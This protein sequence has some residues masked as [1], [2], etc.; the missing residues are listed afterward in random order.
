MKYRLTSAADADVLAILRQTRRDFGRGQLS[1]YAQ[2]IDLGISMIAD[3]PSRPA[4]IDRGDI[5]KG[6]KSFHLEFAAKRRRGAAH[7]LYFTEMRDA[8]GAPE[9]V[10][11]RV[12]HEAMEPKRRLIRALR[13]QDDDS[14]TTPPEPSTRKAPEN[15]S[16]AARAS[17]DPDATPRRR[18]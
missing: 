14:P 1:I 18:R 12:L 6:L 7:M 9:V 10:V 13:D 8:T 4:C 2:I 5:R 16:Q 17:T 15:P 3:N 11:L